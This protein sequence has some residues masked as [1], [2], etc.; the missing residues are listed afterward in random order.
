MNSSV[1]KI[2][3]GAALV[4]LIIAAATLY[5][6][7]E[8]ALQNESDA[9]GQISQEVGLLKP[10][11]TVE[12]YSSIHESVQHSFELPDKDGDEGHDAG[13][14]HIRSVYDFDGGAVADIDALADPSISMADARPARF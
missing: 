2:L 12:A 1:V 14:I 11:K 7:E 5:S 10:A 13:V 8:G 3:F 6:P 9:P 4:A